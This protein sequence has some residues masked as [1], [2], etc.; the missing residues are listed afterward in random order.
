VQQEA[1]PDGEPRFT[2][3]E[4]IREYAL[5]RLETSEEADAIQQ[6]HG[7]YFLALAEVDAPAFVGVPHL[8]WL[9]QIATEHDNLR[10]A[11]AW[12]FGGGNAVVGMCLAGALG[13]FWL[14]HEQVAEG[15]AWLAAALATPAPASA[16][17]AGQA[18][19]KAARAA[20]LLSY[21]FI[22]VEMETTLHEA[23]TLF[24]EVGDTRGIAWTIA[25]RGRTEYGSGNE[26]RDQRN[27]DIILFVWSGSRSTPGTAGG[28]R[29][30]SNP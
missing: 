3:L 30:R 8:T 14:A 25:L 12:A 5:E 26:P 24:R 4:T 13:P 28:A 11:L 29:C 21:N 1:G 22:E 7:E 19:W 20:A 18:A 10:T 6:R 16:A 9:N 15:K 27:I 2:M 17:G 23:L